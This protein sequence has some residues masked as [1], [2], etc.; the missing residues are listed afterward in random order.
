M[1][2]HAPCHTHPWAIMCYF[3]EGCPL[4]HTHRQARMHMHTHAHTHTDTHTRTHT[5]THEDKQA[6]WEG[7]VLIFTVNENEMGGGR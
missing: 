2:Q 7:D 6:L 1:C 5:N 4:S 3:V